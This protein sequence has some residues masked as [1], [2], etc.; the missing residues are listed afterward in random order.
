MHEKLLTGIFI[1]KIVNEEHEYRIHNVYFLRALQERAVVKNIIRERFAGTHD[2]QCAGYP[3]L[4]YRR[5][6]NGVIMD[7]YI[8]LVPHH[9]REKIELSRHIAFNIKAVP[10]FLVR[11]TGECVELP[12][13]DDAGLW[14]VLKHFYF[15]IPTV[16]K[17]KSIQP[18]K[19]LFP[20][21]IAHY[22]EPEILQVAEHERYR[23]HIPW[24]AEDADAVVSLA[25]LAHQSIAD[26][27]VAEL[28]VE[29]EEDARH[30][31]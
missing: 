7:E 10:F 21:V 11:D 20:S 28:I 2:R 12:F 15:I 31:F 16:A 27:I 17:S 22:L 25:I 8:R 3:V 4:V 9:S 18:K 5:A 19:I 1:L 6:V 14:I 13:G 30:I 23:L 29:I 24:D 26:K